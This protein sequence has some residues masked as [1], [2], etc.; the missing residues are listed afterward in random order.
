MWKKFIIHYKGNTTFFRSVLNGFFSSV[1]PN[2]KQIKLWCYF[3]ILITFDICLY[4]DLI[5]NE[6]IFLCETWQNLIYDRIDPW[7]I[8]KMH[9]CKLLPIITNS[10]W[11]LEITFSKFWKNLFKKIMTDYNHPRRII[12]FN[13][14][15][16]IKSNYLNIIMILGKTCCWARKIKRLIRSYVLHDSQ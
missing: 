1:F 3:H 9:K 6:K 15:L 4:F 7:K 10:C 13:F 2:Q 14:H 11:E 8:N 5:V 16:C 12:N